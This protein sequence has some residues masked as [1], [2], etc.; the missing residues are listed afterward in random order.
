ME[1][2]Y[3]IDLSVKYGLGSA[4]ITKLVNII[5][6]TGVHDTDSDRFKKIARHICQNSLIDMPAEELLEELKRH[7]LIAE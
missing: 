4:D 3:L 6:Q 1:N 7:K 2:T 5:Y